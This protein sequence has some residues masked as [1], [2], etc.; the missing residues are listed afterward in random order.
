VVGGVA[1][2]ADGSASPVVAIAG[3]VY[4]PVPG[5]IEVVSL[6]ERFGDDRARNDTLACIREVTADILASTGMI[7]R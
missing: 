7:R 1:D 3:Q 2:L 6:V 5:G 4:E